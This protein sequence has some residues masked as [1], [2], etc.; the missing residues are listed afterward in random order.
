M[1]TSQVSNALDKNSLKESL[2]SLITSCIT[3]SPPA[4]STNSLK[5][6]KLELYICPSPKFF[7]GSINSSPV[8]K[9]AIFGFL[10]TTNSPYPNVAQVP[11]SLGVAVVPF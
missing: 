7:P 3:T 9:I 2:S 8:P 10:E 4:L 1:I 11:I 5:T 6:Y